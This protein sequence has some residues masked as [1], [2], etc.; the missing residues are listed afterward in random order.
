MVTGR[1][2]Y[3]TD[4]L[5]IRTDA[6]AS[7][8][9]YET[10]WFKSGQVLLDSA[11]TDRF[12]PTIAYYGAWYYAS[13]LPPTSMRMTFGK[14]RRMDLHKPNDPLLICRFFAHSG[15][16]WD[17]PIPHG[18]LGVVR[19]AYDGRV[20]FLVNPRQPGP[21]GTPLGYSYTTHPWGTSAQIWN[22]MT[23]DY[24]VVARLD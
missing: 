7:R 2:F 1:M 3:C 13:T 9:S 17:P 20:D 21:R 16:T 8:E 15:G 12:W 11:W 5:L 4:L 6:P 19:G 14:A 22:E 23:W 18:D 10:T 24:D